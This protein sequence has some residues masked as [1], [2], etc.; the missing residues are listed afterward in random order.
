MA[1]GVRCLMPRYTRIRKLANIFRNLVARQDGEPGL[2][3]SGAR[4]SSGSRRPGTSGSPSL[5]CHEILEKSCRLLNVSVACK[6]DARSLDW[7]LRNR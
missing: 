7:R 3:D 1:A 2:P 5:T 4:A 6:T